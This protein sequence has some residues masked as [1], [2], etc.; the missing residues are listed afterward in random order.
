MFSLSCTFPSGFKLALVSPIFWKVLSC[1]LT[2]LTRDHS[3]LLPS[4]ANLSLKGFLCL[5]CPLLH[6]PFTVQFSSVT[7]SCLTLCDPMDCSMPCFPVHH[8][9]RELAQNH[10]HRVGDAIL[11]CLLLLLP[12]IFPSIGVFSNESVLRIR[13]SKYWNF[14]KLNN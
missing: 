9:L 12:S 1:W 4:T 13:W 14:S 10:V 6:C 3:S 2:S 5:L 11:C 7:Q 8:H